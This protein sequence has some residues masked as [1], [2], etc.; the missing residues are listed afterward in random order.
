MNDV[1]SYWPLLLLWLPVS[2]LAAIAL[3]ASWHVTHGDDR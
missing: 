1:F 2:L 3:V